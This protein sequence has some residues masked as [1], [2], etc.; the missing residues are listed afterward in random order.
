MVRALLRR[1]LRV[2][3]RTL[4]WVACVAVPNIARK[5]ARVALL[6][7]RGLARAARA[8]ARDLA[9]STWEFA[10]ELMCLVRGLPRMATCAAQVLARAA[11]CLDLRL[12]RRDVSLPRPGAA[13]WLGASA[14]P[15]Q[16]TRPVSSTD[17][18][19]MIKAL[20]TFVTLPAQ[21]TPMMWHRGSGSL[22]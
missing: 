10:R 14:P 9:H 15:L 1:F 2:L 13:A 5:L 11:T 6:L 8:L 12:R 18:P 19:A 4:V 22:W 17:A 16:A 21:D 20:R 7:A 3:L